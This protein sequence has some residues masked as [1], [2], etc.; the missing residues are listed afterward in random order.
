MS[1][2]AGEILVDRLMSWGVDTVFGLPGDGINGIIEAFRQRQDD[3]RFIQVR[4]EEAAAFMACGY[5]KFTGDRVS[6]SP[7]R[8]RAASIC[9]M[10]FTT[11]KWT[12]Q[13]VL[14]ITGLQF[15]DL[16]GHA[17]TAG[18]RTGQAVHGRGVYNERVMGP[19]HMQQRGRA[20][21]PHRADVPRRLSHHHPSRYSGA[22]SRTKGT[23]P[24]ATV[25][26][27]SPTYAP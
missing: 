23:A 8:A 19:Q 3:I 13:P 20:G 7:H 17:H 18:R 5:A 9:S 15:H 11:P 16:I 25:R 27:T 21:L 12:A 26:N 14:A 10:A 4:H 2:T 1:K 24:S 6:A 22:G